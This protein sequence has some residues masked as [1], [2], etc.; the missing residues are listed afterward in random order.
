MFRETLSELQSE[1]TQRSQ[2]LIDSVHSVSVDARSTSRLA[3]Y[4]KALLPT[5]LTLLVA[6]TGFIN[7]PGMNA[8]GQGRGG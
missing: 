6:V 2:E 3:A 4:G 5:A 7:D 8:G 1:A